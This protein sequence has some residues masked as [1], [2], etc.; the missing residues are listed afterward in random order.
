MVIWWWVSSVSTTQ[1]VQGKA[2]INIPS[3]KVQVQ[4]FVK[5]YEKRLD[6]IQK[7]NLEKIV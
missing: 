4:L 3:K 7:K 1:N 5:F 2:D 6:V